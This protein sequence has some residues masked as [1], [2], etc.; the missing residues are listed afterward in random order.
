MKKA[1]KNLFL[2]W[3]PFQRRAQTL[4]SAFDLEVHYYHYPWEER[5]K[6]FKAFSYIGKFLATMRDMIRN[7]P[8]YVFIQLAPAPLLYA[9][10]LY[11]KLTGA[12]YISDCHNTMIYDGPFIKWPLAKQLL[13]KSY[14]LLVHNT[15]VQAHSDALN[16][17]SRILRDPLPEMKVPED[18]AVVSGISLKDTTYIIVPCSMAEDEPVQELFEAAAKVPEVK[19]VFTWYFNKLPLELRSKAPPNIEFTGFLEEPDFNALYANAN[20]ALVLTT[21]EGTQP[22]G[23]AEA[24]SLGI[25][26]IVSN[27]KTTKRLYGDSPV[28]V[29]NDPASIAQGIHY[30]MDNQDTVAHKV[31]SLKQDLVSDSVN[32][33]EAIK[34]LL[35]G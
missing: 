21:R 19:I 33:I 13:R 34:K 35:P 11:C 32:Q 18:V 16:L 14:I 2:V 6:I 10:A 20:A 31:S 22:S 24:I 8:Q 29:E 27:I 15:D 23:A 7:R 28:Y 3:C 30:A 26:L 9:A 17:P 25:P 1:G 5:G 4:A 12:R